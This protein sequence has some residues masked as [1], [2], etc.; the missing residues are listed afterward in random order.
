[1]SFIVFQHFGPGSPPFTTAKC[2]VQGRTTEAG[3]GER[4]AG[5]TTVC[6]YTSWQVLN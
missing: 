4:E 5:C 1:M 2:G 6:Q 3:R